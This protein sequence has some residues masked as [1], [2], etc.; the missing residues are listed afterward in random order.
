M[1]RT[2]TAELCLGRQYSIDWVLGRLE[3]KQPLGSLYAKSSADVS[4]LVFSVPL[5]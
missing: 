3:R 4:H 5:T 1:T 2:V